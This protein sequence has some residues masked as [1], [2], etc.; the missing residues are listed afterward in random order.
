M[1]NTIHPANYKTGTFGNKAALLPVCVVCGLGQI[2]HKKIVKGVF[3]AASFGV[4]LWVGIAEYSPNAHS[5]F[6]IPSFLCFA[7]AL[8]IWCYGA[9]DYFDLHAEKQLNTGAEWINQNIAKAPST[10]IESDIKS[11]QPEHKTQTASIQEEENGQDNF[12]T[13][14]LYEQARIF[15]LQDKLDEAKS[16]YEKILTYT[17]HD[18]ECYFQ[19]GKISLDMENRTQAQEYFEKCTEFDSEQKWPQEIKFL[20]EEYDAQI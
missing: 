7:T 11:P 16:G 10:N 15:H 12:D 6:N 18:A 5:T 19:L 14:Q 3:L 8:A 17:P 9:V 1:N 20:L 13:G 4:C 2:L